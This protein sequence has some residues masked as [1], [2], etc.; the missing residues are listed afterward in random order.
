ML[1]LGLKHSSRGI[2]YA[3]VSEGS[4]YVSGGSVA[5]SQGFT[6]EIERLTGLKTSDY[7]VVAVAEQDR[8]EVQGIRTVVLPMLP[9]L[10]HA[11]WAN[12][13]TLDIKK[14]DPSYPYLIW[15]DID[16]T[17]TVLLAE[18]AD[19]VKAVH[20]MPEGS[21]NRL[22]DLFSKTFE[23]DLLAAAD[24]GDQYAMNLKRIPLERKLTAQALMDQV[25]E[26][27]YDITPDTSDTVHAELESFR[28][29]DTAAALIDAYSESVIA[30]LIDQ[31]HTLG[32]RSVM[33]SGPLVFNERF[34]VLLAT[35][36]EELGYEL[37]LPPVDYADNEAFALAV[38]AEYFPV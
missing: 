38:Y 8:I 29:Y 13:V 20:Q 22:A 16:D 25:D 24:L 27:Q 17:A 34:R 32:V 33:Y 2:D 1:V 5:D 37:R 30:R 31:A 21:L 7:D 18:S 14:E 11:P 35:Q 36:T 9:A 15:I 6:E 4:Q 26:A 19:I 23:H 12:D 3:V 10:A 28:A